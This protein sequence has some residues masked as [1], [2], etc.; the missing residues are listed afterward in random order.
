MERTP[1]VA[2]TAFDLI[3]DADVEGRVA[4][5]GHGDCLDGAGWSP[6]HCEVGYCLSCCVFHSVV[7]LRVM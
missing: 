7:F 2:V 3:Q 5:V 4:P 1:E 6:C